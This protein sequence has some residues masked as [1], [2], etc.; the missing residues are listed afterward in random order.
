MLIETTDFH[1]SFKNNYKINKFKKMNY[2]MFYKTEL[3][4][5]LCF[6][7][8]GILKLLIILININ[9]LF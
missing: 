3:S 8:I 9:L 5:W 2:S 7:E 6:M 1:I 4:Q